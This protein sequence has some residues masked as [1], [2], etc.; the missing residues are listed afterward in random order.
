[1]SQIKSSNSPTDHL[2]HGFL[3][4]E[5]SYGCV[6]DLADAHINVALLVPLANDDC[7]ADPGQ[8][9]DLND[10]LQLQMLDL[11]GKPN[12]LFLSHRQPAIDLLPQKNELL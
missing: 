2:V 5:T 7:G 11:P 9:S 1:M 12:D 4:G 10:V 6:Q 8:T 3:A